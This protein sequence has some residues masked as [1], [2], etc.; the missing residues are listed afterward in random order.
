MV[1]LCISLVERV[2]WKYGFPDSED[3]NPKNTRKVGE[4]GCSE[5]AASGRYLVAVLVSQA[6]G[7]Q[8]NRL[9]RHRIVMVW[10]PM[11]SLET[12]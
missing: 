10:G 1:E 9:C 12:S 2:R 11:Q 3:S 5:G 4:G 7:T 8:Q 6:I